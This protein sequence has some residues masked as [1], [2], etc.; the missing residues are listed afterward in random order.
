MAEG[1]VQQDRTILLAVRGCL[2]EP[3]RV[4]Q[5]AKKTGY[6]ATGALI[7]LGKKEE[8]RYALSTFRVND[9]AAASLRWK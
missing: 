6:Q 3:R 1:D 2:V 9:V 4:Q 7:M 8:K 5:K